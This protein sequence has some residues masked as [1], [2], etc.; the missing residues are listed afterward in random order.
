MILQNFDLKLEIPQHTSCVP[1]NAERAKYQSDL[2]LNIPKKY[3]KIDRRD[4]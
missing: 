1:V 3:M 2:F 4:L